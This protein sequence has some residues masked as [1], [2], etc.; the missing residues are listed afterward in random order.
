MGRKLIQGYP[1]TLGAN[2]ANVKLD[3]GGNCIGMWIAAGAVAVR[4]DGGG[5]LTFKAGDCLMFDPSNEYSRIVLEDLSGSENVI[6][7]ILGYGN[8]A[9]SNNADL[10]NA[11]LQMIEDNTDQLETI[12]TAIDG[13]TDGVEALLSAI[14]G[15]T[16][17]IEAQLATLEGY[18]DQVETLLTAISSNT[19]Q[20]ETLLTNLGV[21]AAAIEVLLTA[22][23]SNTD[24]VEG[25]LTDLDGNT[26]TLE[27]LLTTI[28]DNADTV[29]SLT[30]SVRDNI[31]ALNSSKV[32][33]PDAASANLNSLVRGLMQK[34]DDQSND[35]GDLPDLILASNASESVSF[36]VPMYRSLVY[37]YLSDL[38]TCTS[39]DIEISH[40]A[41]G[42]IWEVESTRTHSAINSLKH[43]AVNEISNYVKV[44]IKNEVGGAGA[45]AK[46]RVLSVR[47]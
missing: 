2:E 21:D 36:N 39:A 34:I 3:I 43:N 7:V 42:V 45:V 35:S 31:G 26:D 6:E 15:N 13:N 32:E 38:G 46:T 10:T 41:D 44:E 37:S 14:D 19:D 20:V 22:L 17:G 8:I 5:P 1:I 40:S 11:L 24:G 18:T 25:L 29:E 47:E 23:E 16:D 33:D 4:V 12:L 28:R 30:S 27:S 9:L